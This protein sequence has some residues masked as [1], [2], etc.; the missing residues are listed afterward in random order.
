MITLFKIRFNS[1]RIVQRR[2]SKPVFI[3]FR[4]FST[5]HVEM[6]LEVNCRRHLQWNKRRFAKSEGLNLVLTDTIV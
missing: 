3:I 6:K 2:T 5:V 1:I 4:L